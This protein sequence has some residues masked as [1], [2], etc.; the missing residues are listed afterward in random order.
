MKGNALKHDW[1]G[2]Y[3]TV[4][5]D[6]FYKF[7]L[8]YGNDR[9]LKIQA[10]P[11]SG[12]SPEI[13]FIEYSEHFLVLY[14]RSGEDDYFTL[15]AIFRRAAHKIYRTGLKQN[16]IKQNKKFLQLVTK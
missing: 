15:A 2:K 5:H 9:L 16:I 3:R 7:L 12:I 10:N 1:I 14:R 6:R 11:S 4:G 8:S 13:E